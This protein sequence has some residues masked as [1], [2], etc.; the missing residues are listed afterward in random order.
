[1]K[2]VALSLGGDITIIFY[3]T[4]DINENIVTIQIGITKGN[5]K[6]NME[7]H[8]FVKFIYQWIYYLNE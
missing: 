6:R 5:G 4:V 8:N 3:Y 1:M 2:Y 7:V